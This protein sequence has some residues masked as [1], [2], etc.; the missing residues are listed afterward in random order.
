V[1]EVFARTWQ[2]LATERHP[3]LPRFVS[4]AAAERSLDIDPLRLTP[5]A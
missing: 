2:T 1:L 3:G 5:M 4:E